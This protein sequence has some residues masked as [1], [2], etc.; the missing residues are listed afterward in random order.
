MSKK[1]GNLMS[2][3]ILII[4]ISILLLTNFTVY[5]DTISTVSATFTYYRNTYTLGYT[6]NCT[7][8][9]FSPS[10]S[11]EVTNS[12]I[13]VKDVNGTQIYSG[14]NGTFNVSQNQFPITFYY[15]DT[16]ENSRID[17]NIKLN[18]D[19]AS[20]NIL[21][22]LNDPNSLDDAFNN[23]KNAV[24]NMKNKGFLGQINEASNALSILGYEYP[25]NQGLP[26]NLN[27]YVT[28]IPGTKPI[29]V[30][31][32]SHY[33]MQLYYIRELFSGIVWVGLVIYLIQYIM[34]RFKV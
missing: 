28:F 19:T 7:S 12:N 1:G 23:L 20:N 15:Q 26:S 22:F 14:S 17:M 24:D 29:N 8:V 6:N 31:D 9:S 27:F 4:I 21:D 34:P 18:S 33:T 13:V 25:D 30:L 3:N 16:N 10:F 5:A 32:L 11:S 2:K